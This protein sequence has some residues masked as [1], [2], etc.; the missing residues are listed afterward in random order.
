[1][2]G[3]DTMEFR[4][5]VVWRLGVDTVEFRGLVV[6]RLGVDTMES[7]W[8]VVW[9]LGVDPMEDNVGRRCG[10]QMG[11]WSP[12][13]SGLEYNCKFCGGKV[14]EIWRQMVD[15][16]EARWFRLVVKSGVIDMEAKCG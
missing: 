2:L 5:V 15:G 8:L 13:V 6:W 12:D 3:V 11:A 9:M 7:W 14:N 10:G 4:W 16:T 1:M